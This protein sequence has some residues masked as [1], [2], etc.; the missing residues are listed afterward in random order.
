MSSSALFIM[1]DARQ[2]K[3]DGRKP[4]RRAS[5]GKVGMTHNSIAPLQTK[6]SQKSAGA[7][8]SQAENAS[9]ANLVFNHTDFCGSQRAYHSSSDSSLR[10]PLAH[11]D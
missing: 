5:C 9:L 2:S 3:L 6:R 7:P 4:P 1:P 10:D 8:V 11:T